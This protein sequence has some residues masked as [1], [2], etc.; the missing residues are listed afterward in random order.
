MEPATVESK[1]V[2]YITEEFAKLKSPNKLKVIP[3]GGSKAWVS[4]PK[5]INYVAGR[6]A[7]KKVYGIEPD[8]TREG[9]SIPIT[10]T[11]E[12]ETKKNVLLLPMGAGDDGAHSQNEKLNVVN[13]LNGIK[14]L[15]TYLDEIANLS[16]N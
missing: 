6:N 10:L 14:L 5:H 16:K 4:D 11:F 2:K 7:T 1:V 15:G 12:E 3:Y 9:G 8:F 13:Y